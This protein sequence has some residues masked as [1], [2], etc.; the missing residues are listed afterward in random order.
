M[1]GHLLKAVAYFLIYKAMVETGLSRPLDLLLRE[2]KQ[3]N[4]FLEQRVVERTAELDD[5]VSRLQDEIIERELTE[6]ELLQSSREL[7]Q[8]REMI[9]RL[10]RLYAVLYA[11]NH[12]IVHIRD[13]NALFREF[14]RAAVEYGGFRL[15]WVGLLTESGGVE[16]IATHGATGYLNDIR[17]DANTGNDQAEPTLMAM[18]EGFHICNDFRAGSTASPW[19]ERARAHGLS[20]SA[21]I[22]LR[23]NDKIIGA[24]SLYAG[25]TDFFD[26]RQVELLR[27]MGT[28]V[29]FAL[30]N[31]ARAEEIRQKDRLLI[32][33]SRQ[34]AMGEM[35]NNIAHQWRQ[36]LNGLG[37]IIQS[38]PI[39][40]ETGKFTLEYLESTQDKAMKLITHMSQTIED[41][42]NYFKPD[43]EKVPFKVESAVSKTLTL[44]EENFKSHRIVIEVDE[45][46]VSHINGYPNEYSQVLLNIMINARDALMERS[47]TD[48]KIVISTRTENGKTVV[49]I[50]DN[51]GGIP[52][53][54]I[55]KIFEPYFTTK[56]PDRG[57]GVGLFMSKAIIEQNMNGRLTVRNTAEGAEF[58]I[59][60]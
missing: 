4:E 9:G 23:L 46:Q 35:I 25:E 30:D 33:Q 22:A 47:I 37:L 2:I 53:E 32:Q 17:I 10:N 49:T 13:R 58:R 41:F 28:D 56:G 7:Y 51:A 1:A 29:S 12:A 54:I 8:S 36:P 11:T 38:L 14:C 50:G 44:I 3:S 43:K 52:D 45:G 57:S 6:E 5:T 31:L 55:G 34:A 18:R 26:T 15:A 60:V 40:Y 21:S 24:L 20:A 42:R 39:M 59:E 19:H 16:V 48:P 27:Q